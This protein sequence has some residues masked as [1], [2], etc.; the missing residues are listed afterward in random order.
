MKTINCLGYSIYS[1][2]F[3]KEDF[4]SKK[5]VI[6]TINPHC[7]CEAKKDD[8]YSTALH[9]SDI[10]LPDGIGIVWAIKVLTKEIITRVAGSD[11]HIGLLERMNKSAGKVFYM[12]SSPETLLKIQERIK[13][14]YPAIVTGSYSPP[15]K[16]VFTDEDNAQIL[17]A[18]NEFQPDV[19]FIGMTAPKQEKWVH[20]HKEQLNAK[21][22]ASVGAVFDFYAGTVK[23]SGKFWI[24]LGL[25]WLPRLLREPKRLWRRNFIS[26]P[27]FILEVLKAKIK[28]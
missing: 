26:T 1:E 9:Q 25:E 20:Q 23:R 18:I 27:S 24:S 5:T 11:L 13:R 17:A 7:Y 10:L 3:L 28:Q 12:G 2:D 19:L 14:E 16:A 8:L 21:I 6:N 22:I 4:L 15:Y